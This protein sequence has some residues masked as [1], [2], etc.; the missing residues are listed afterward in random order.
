V[1]RIRLVP[2]DGSA[3]LRDDERRLLPH[4]RDGKYIARDYFLSS[5]R[6]H[7]LGAATLA[8]QLGLQDSLIKTLGRW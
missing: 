3:Q 7:S 5:C 4:R 8:A 6:P 1:Y 2:G